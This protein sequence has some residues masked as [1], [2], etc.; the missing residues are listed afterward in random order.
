MSRL[1][2]NCRKSVTGQIDARSLCQGS[3]IILAMCLVSGVGI[4]LAML[5]THL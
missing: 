3:S 4:A 1:I 2:E 5:I